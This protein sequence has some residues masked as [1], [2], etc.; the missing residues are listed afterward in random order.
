MKDK[1]RVR[2]LIKLKRVISLIIIKLK[3]R[4]V[5]A[6]QNNDGRMK[7]QDNRLVVDDTSYYIS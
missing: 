2:F 4:F 3:A 7:D 6:D 5:K 1:K